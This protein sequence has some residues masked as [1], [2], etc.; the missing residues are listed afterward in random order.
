MPTAIYP[1]ASGLTTH[2]A[3]YT[4]EIWSGK[5]LVKFYTAT[6]FAAISNTDFEG[7]IKEK[8]DTVHIRT[9]P[10]ITIRDY[11]IGQNLLQERPAPGV[12]DLLIDKGK[13]YCMSI[14]DVE[15][16]QSDLNY[17]EKWTDD[18]GM[19]M[20]ITVDSDI[21][22]DVYA[23]AH[24]SNKG[25]SA[26]AITSSIQLGTTSD[27]VTVD[28]SDILDYIV[29]MGTVLDE[30]DV[31]ETQRWLVIPALF[32]GMIKKSDLKDA[33]LAGDGTSI[34]RNGRIGTIDRFTIY[35]S[36]QIATTT[37]SGQTVYNCLFG[38]P[39]ALTFASQLI[40]NE[41]LKNPNDFGDLLRG[42]QVF[43][44]KTIKTEAMGHFYATKG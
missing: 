11:T 31:P 1:V 12:V 20:K 41:M 3:T 13:Y 2:S 44:Y 29:D 30:Q 42:L 9:I 22:A 28:K 10:D 35:S 19:Q 8:G 24:A 6:V 4:P 43:G 16:A 14:N 7:E 36:N 27:F 5:T 34:M 26:G 32:C 40:K 33:S 15:V 25:N 17:M 38:H 37:D 18:A 21:L 23:D 39:T